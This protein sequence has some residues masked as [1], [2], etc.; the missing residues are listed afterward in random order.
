MVTSLDM[1]LGENN[2]GTFGDL[3]EDHNAPSIDEGLVYHQS[4]QLE[5]GRCL[6][7]LNERQKDVLSAF[8]GIG[9]P[10]PASLEEIGIRLNLSKERVRQIRD[11]AL[12]QL[13]NS[14]K[15]DLL[16]QFLGN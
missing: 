9:R 16:K 11:K 12:M 7:S 6:K 15:T 10:A 1:P 2:D 3:L 8:F 13:K 5:V 14:R 4:L